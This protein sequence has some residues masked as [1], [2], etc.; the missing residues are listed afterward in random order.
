M[1]FSENNNQDHSELTDEA[2][3]EWL[4]AYFAYIKDV[5]TL[6]LELE[7]LEKLK[8][9]P[10]LQKL[11]DEPG[12][13]VEVLE[14]LRQNGK[15]P[16]SLISQLQEAALKNTK[17]AHEKSELFQKIWR[18]IR[19][20]TKSFAVATS[21]GGGDLLANINSLLFIFGFWALNDR[22]TAD[23]EE[24]ELLHSM[25]LIMIVRRYYREPDALNDAIPVET[26]LKNIYG[27]SEPVFTDELITQSQQ[28][29]DELLTAGV[30]PHAIL[31]V[32]KRRFFHSPLYKN[33][34]AA[35]TGV[36][37][38]INTSLRASL[39]GE[40]NDVGW[41]TPEAIEGR[42]RARMQAI[43]AAGQK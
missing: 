28:F 32:L 22:M 4:R 9:V 2:A 24:R 26:V 27:E 21:L 23:P 30:P 34:E 36:M 31:T 3:L 16:K 39:N 8:L 18:G 43:A 25:A 19:L 11:A 42:R 41:S 37:E 12:M 40:D 15:Y 20:F 7:L 10:F 33:V 5:P 13:T 35:K 1:P 38:R 6:K 17:E 14:E 29:I